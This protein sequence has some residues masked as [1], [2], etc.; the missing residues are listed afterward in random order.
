MDLFPTSHLDDEALSASLDAPEGSDEATPAHLAGC[1]ECARR[2]RQLAA[3]RAA[4]AG[5]PVEPL[6]ELTRRRL[7][8]RALADSSEESPGQPWRRRPALAGG[9][10]AAILAVLV[11]VPFLTREQ[12]RDGQRLSAT[13]G[14]GPA[15]AIF[16]GDLG[17][18]SGPQDI[19][20]RLGATTMAESVTR[21][22]AVADQ[23]AGK[24]TATTAGSPA[25]GVAEAAPAD[26]VPAPVAP[27]A[28]VPSP[29]QRSS[30]A[31]AARAPELAPPAVGR[32]DQATTNKCTSTLAAGPARG[33]RLVATGFGT[34][35]GT[36]V[37]ISVFAT[38]SGEVAYLTDRAGCGLLQHYSL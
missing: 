32:T 5:A 12:Q 25:A 7:L 34:L 13:A 9:V 37:V 4:L 24:E 10:A 1:R 35:R 15:A 16:L 17:E 19:R 30:G 38:P 23:S 11:A 28:P 22:R 21:Q 29:V 33:A 26:A 18:V 36:P 2:R 27:A 20:M 14:S 3:A 6:E 31:D 8:S